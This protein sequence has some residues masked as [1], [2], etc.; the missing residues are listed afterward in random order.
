M[1]PCSSTTLPCLLT[2]FP[3]SDDKSSSTTSSSGSEYGST[4]PL[5]LP[6]LSMM[7]PSSSTALPSNFFGSPSTTLPTTLCSESSTRPSLTTTKP[8]KPENG[9]SGFVS[10]SSGGMSSQ[11]PTTLPD[12]LH[13]WPFSSIFLPASTLGLPSTRRAIGTPSGPITFPCLLHVSPLR[14]DRSTASGSGSSAS[15]SVYLS[16]W[17]TTPPRLSIT[18]PSSSTAR[19]TSFFGS[20]STSWPTR[21]PFSSSTQ[22]S[23]TTIRPSRPANS[24]SA[25]SPSSCGNVLAC[26][27]TW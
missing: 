26:P 18:S 2:F 8:S 13:I 15:G 25:L 27:I 19:P 5:T 22:P 24:A 14:S 6:Y 12:S 17:P 10:C 21:L 7:S 20:P 23:L 9:P 3:A 1:V 4:W 16:A 11:R